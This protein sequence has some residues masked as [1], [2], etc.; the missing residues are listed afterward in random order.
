[1][2]V[3]SLVT[4][5]ANRVATLEV[6][7]VYRRAFKEASYSTTMTMAYGIVTGI[8][9]NGE[10]SAIAALE[11]E[12]G[13]NPKLTERLFTDGEDLILFNADRDSFKAMK[14]RAIRSANQDVEKATRDWDKAVHMREAL[15]GAI[16]RL[17]AD[18]DT[19]KDVA[20]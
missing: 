20:E 16:A 5:N 8:D 12:E 18:P 10:Q 3:E 2:K 19:E 1:M 13:Y 4:A 17:A 14:A 7:D 9:H 6:G 15:N 11:I